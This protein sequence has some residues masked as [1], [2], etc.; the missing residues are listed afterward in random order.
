MQFWQHILQSLNQQKKSIILYVLKS[1]G[2]SPGRQGFKMV[3]SEDGEMM[4]SIGGGIMEH[5][6]VELAKSKLNNKDFSIVFKHQIHSKEVAENQSGMICSGEQSV[7]LIPILEKDVKQIEQIIHCL[8]HGATGELE[9]SQQ[10]LK[11]IKTKPDEPFSFNFL[12]E[13]NWRYIEKIGFKKFAYIIGGGHVGK[14]LNK[15]LVDL[16]FH[17]TVIDDRKNL[18][19]LE[20]N[21]YAHQKII[22]DYKNLSTEI[23]EGDDVFIFIMTFGYRTDL[24]VLQQLITKKFAFMGMMGSH[25]K[26]KKLMGEMKMLGYK[27][28]QLDTVHSPIGLPI[29]SRTPQEIAVSI[30]AQLIQ[31]QNKDLP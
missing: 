22:V 16:E 5:K 13:N 28:E 18:N 12:N 4:G 24:I 21:N 31:L 9:L 8:Q 17:C 3:V 29:K 10:G 6:L 1:K 15:L 7:V 23:R 20:N 30:A 2:S 14:A 26:I 27:E 25:E 11:F 19:T